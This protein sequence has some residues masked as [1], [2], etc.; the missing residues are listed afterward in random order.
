MPE[1]PAFDSLPLQKDGPPGNAWGLFGADDQLGRLNFLTP[2]V[3]KAAASEIQVGTRVS[4]D[5]DLDKPRVPGY[6]RQT[7]RHRILNKAPSTQNDDVVEFN[8]QGGSQWD[9]LRHFGYQSY[10]KFYNGRTQDNFSVGDD[11]GI[12][13]WV[14]NGGIVGRGVL[15]DWADWAVKNGIDPDPFRSA[16][17]ELKHLKRIVE[18]CNIEF[19]SGDILFVRVG[20]VRAY[21][22]LPSEEHDGLF[23]KADS[24][25]VGLEATQDSLRWLW[26]K[27]FAAVVS[28]SPAFERGPINGPFNHPDVNIHQW[29]LAGWGMP[30]GELFDLERLAQECRRLGRWSFFVPGGVASPPNAVA[31]F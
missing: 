17:V 22:E 29:C 30:I 18:D 5:W 2:E 25:F 15:L 14:E 20:F 7:F 1:I 4:L 6:N 9:G 13:I 16:P 31:I 21:E 3:V 19:R 8:T 12:N 26:E 11:M 23:T 10:E 28:D 27:Q 24:R